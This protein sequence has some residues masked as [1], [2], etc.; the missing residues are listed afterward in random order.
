MEKQ[1]LFE[2]DDCAPD[3]HEHFKFTFLAK[4]GMHYDV[5]MHGAK[6]ISKDDYK[7]ILQ[8]GNITVE[9]CAGSQNLK[10]YK[11]IK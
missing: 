11:I 4:I 5:W 3:A 2:E 9:C 6:Q 8:N 7:S 1:L 10:C